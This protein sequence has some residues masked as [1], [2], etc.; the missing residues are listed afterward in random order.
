M[1]IKDKANGKNPLENGTL[2]STL[3]S[4]KE[5]NKESKKY[6]KWNEIAPMI[7]YDANGKKI[8]GPDKYF[9]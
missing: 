8:F 9:E 1:L 7:V 2:E 3:Q 5:S 6:G 4:K